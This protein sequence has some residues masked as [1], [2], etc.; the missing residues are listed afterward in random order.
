MGYG[1]TYQLRFIAFGIVGLV[2][3]MAV[4]LAGPARSQQAAYDS[5]AVD[6]AAAESPVLATSG[7]GGSQE[8]TASRTREQDPAAAQSQAQSPAAE[9]E[10]TLVA[11]PKPVA[12]S[13]CERNLLVSGDRALQIRSGQGRGPVI[14]TVPVT[15]KYLGTGM[16]A[17][18][19]KQSSNGRY[20]QVTIPWSGSNRAGW[21]D[22][23]GL[24]REYSRITVRASVSRHEIVVEQD[25]RPILRIP[26]ATGANASPS[27]K[28]RFWVTDRVST[29]TGWNQGSFGHFA[30]G[31]SGRQPNLPAGWTGGDQMAIHGTNN[32]G[33]IGTDASA[34]CLRITAQNLENLKPHLLVG[35]PVIIEA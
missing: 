32:L 9:P 2:I 8:V 33:S 18:V 27:P 34:G 21:I 10:A 35:T 25:C 29:G 30:F 12:A 31:I 17:W 15:S 1:G 5:Q 14:G 24:R 16:K 7:A 26:A 13:S 22:L 4:L 11:D 20:G 23:R 3:T 19:I 6:K 28:G